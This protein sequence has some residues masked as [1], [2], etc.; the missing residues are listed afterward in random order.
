MGLF[1]FGKK[2]QK[3]AQARRSGKPEQTR[4][5]VPVSVYEMPEGDNDGPIYTFDA[6]PLGKLRK[7]QKVRM[8]L[9][10]GDVDMYDVYSDEWTDSRA[11]NNTNCC[12]TYGGYAVGYLTGM[13]DYIQ[14]IVD[15]HGYVSVVVRYDGQNPHHGIP[16]FWALLPDRQW[17]MDELGIKPTQTGRR[18]YRNEDPDAVTLRIYDDEWPHEVQSGEHALTLSVLPT[19]SGSKAKPHIVVSLDGVRCSEVTARHGCYKALESLVGAEIG[20]CAV[21]TTVSDEG[22]VTHTLRVRRRA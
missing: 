2:K 10:R 20:R 1:G 16:E 14:K 9:V 13:R 8:V 6:R 12:L 17:F 5:M 7:G 3:K 11:Y 19:P 21:S 15:K 22:L 18:N 4:V